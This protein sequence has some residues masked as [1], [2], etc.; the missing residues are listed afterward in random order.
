M[1]AS[2]VKLCIKKRDERKNGRTDER[3]N[4]P[5]AICPSNFCEVSC[6]ISDGSIVDAFI[7]PSVHH[8]FSSETAGIQ[9]NATSLPLMVWQLKDNNIF[10]C[11][12][13]SASVVRL[14]VCH[15]RLF[16]RAAVGLCVCRP[17]VYPLRHLLRS[18]WTEFNQT[19][20]IISP[21]SKDVRICPSR[22]LFLNHWAKFN[23][24]CYIT[25]PW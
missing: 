16:F 3:T 23:Q 9:P 20:Y 24:A 11:I 13:Q 8:T 5:E 4:V 18:Q 19:C 14:S 10:P 2:K 15:A 6:I 25:A 12:R 17:S 1:H 21:K 7:R 22:Y